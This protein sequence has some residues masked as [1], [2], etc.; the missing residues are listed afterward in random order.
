[1]VK[2]WTAEDF[3]SV[4]EDFTGKVKKE[5]FITGMQCLYRRGRGDDG[6]RD[7]FRFYEGQRQIQVEEPKQEKKEYQKLKGGSKP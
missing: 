4:E 7:Q 6:L 2:G 1:M 3:I 5:N